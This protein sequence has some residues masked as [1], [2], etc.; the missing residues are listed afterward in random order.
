MLTKKSEEE[1]KFVS[2]FSGITRASIVEPRC[3]CYM[4]AHSFTPLKSYLF[5]KIFLFFQVKC[6]KTPWYLK[7]WAATTATNC[8]PAES[9][10]S[11]KS[12]NKWGKCCRACSKWSGSSFG[13][14]KVSFLSKY[15]ENGRYGMFDP[16]LS[17]LASFCIYRMWHDPISALLFLSFPPLISHE[18]STLLLWGV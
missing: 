4:V 18:I 5:K 12:E 3:F 16:F 14:D 10:R 7:C 8:S 13:T 17:Q 15:L 9:T 2:S 6:Q 11:R 1:W